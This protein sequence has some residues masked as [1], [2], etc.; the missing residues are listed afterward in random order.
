MLNAAFLDH[1]DLRY[2]VIDANGL[3]LAH[4]YG[5]LPNAIAISNKRL[6]ANEAEKID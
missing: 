5:E 6:T 3:A 1:G 2:R 4:V